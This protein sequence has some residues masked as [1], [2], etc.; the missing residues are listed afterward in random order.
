MSDREPPRRRVPGPA[1]S[2]GRGAARR[3]A[4][5]ARPARRPGPARPAPKTIKLGSPRPRLR[6]LG[7][8]LTLA[9]LALAVRLVQMQAVDARTYASQAEQN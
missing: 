4:P 8:A 7:P 1:R 5:G 6:L 9:L 3:P 2:A